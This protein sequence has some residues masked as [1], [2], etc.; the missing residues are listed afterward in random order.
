MS[1]LTA[2][3]NKS[4]ENAA[5]KLLVHFKEQYGA[6]IFIPLGVSETTT[7]AKI[8]P[9]VVPAFEQ[10]MLS[11]EGNNITVLMKDEKVGEVFDSFMNAFFNSLNFIAKGIMNGLGLKM[12]WADFKVSLANRKQNNQEGYIRRK[13][14]LTLVIQWVFDEIVNDLKAQGMSV[15]ITNG[16]ENFNSVAEAIE[17][18]EIFA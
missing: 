13:N 8:V 4:V 15:T 3:L 16:T 5:K 14:N 7:P 17:K 10:S 6:M 18:L 11:A 12:M 2:T 1:E 9:S